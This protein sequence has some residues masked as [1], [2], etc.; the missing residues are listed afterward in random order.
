SFMG[1]SF[2]VT[3]YLVKPD[4]GEVVRGLLIPSTGSAGLLTVMALIG[5]TVVPYN[6]FLHASLVG[7]KWAKPEDLKI[8]RKELVVAILLGGFTSMAIVISAAVPG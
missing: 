5:T 3:A 6:L 8:A 1:I 4:I 7:E 2:L